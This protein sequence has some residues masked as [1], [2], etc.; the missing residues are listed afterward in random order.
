MGLVEDEEGF[1]REVGREKPG[2]FREGLAEQIVEIFA[3]ID[4]ENSTRE[5]GVEEGRNQTDHLI[6]HSVFR[7]PN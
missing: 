5:K 3:T 2:A 1:H 4:E 7:R 6:A